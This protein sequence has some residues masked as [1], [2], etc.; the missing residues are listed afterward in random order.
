MGIYNTVKCTEKNVS[1]RFKRN[2]QIDNQWELCCFLKTYLAHND[3][4]LEL[5]LSTRLRKDY[6]F[7]KP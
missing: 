1:A 7:L 6:D 3:L 4:D 5:N 2:F